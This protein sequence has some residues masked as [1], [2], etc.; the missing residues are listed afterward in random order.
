MLIE[1]LAFVHALFEPI[2]DPFAPSWAAIFR[3]RERYPLEGLPWRGGGEKEVERT[4]SGLVK[5]GL[6]VRHRAV[7]KTVGAR[8]TEAG[9]AQAWKLL[10]IPADQASTVL[11]EVNQ[12]APKGRWLAETRLNRG[13]GW[14]DGHQQEL[15]MV[16]AFNLPA[17]VM[18]W[19]ES[20]SDVRGRVGY[21]VTAEGLRTLRAARGKGSGKKEAPVPDPRPE[22]MKLYIATYRESLSWLDS[23]DEIAVDERGEIGPCPLSASTWDDLPLRKSKG[24]PLTV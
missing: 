8:L 21:K 9:L 6:I 3:L 4:L 18:G 22:V 13:R 10:G 23:R 12:L 7:R 17:L 1:C 16:V 24:R 11:R 15:K 14:G 5:G 2:R 20:L 19:I